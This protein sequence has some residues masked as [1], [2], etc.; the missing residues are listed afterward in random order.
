MLKLL[1]IASEEGVTRIER[2]AY[3][4][5]LT[6]LLAGRTDRV[7]RRKR[8]VEA[9][10][11]EWSKRGLQLMGVVV[12]VLLVPQ[13]EVSRSWVRKR[14]IRCGWTEFCGWCDACRGLVP[15]AA[16][17]QSLSGKTT[18]FRHQRADQSMQMM[19]WEYFFQLSEVESFYG[20]TIL[21]QT[22]PSWIAYVQRSS[23][24]SLRIN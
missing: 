4:E 5:A 6:K 23:N 21:Q 18:R 11:A 24:H 3:D 15:E 12:V 7:A 16:R 19:H 2:G 13:W 8:V 17:P 14:L 10:G 1:A 9:I 22:I 20:N